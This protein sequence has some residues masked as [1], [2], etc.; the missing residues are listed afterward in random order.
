MPSIIPCLTWVPKGAARE[1]PVRYELSRD[2]YAKVKELES[3]AT[4][5]E[6]V[7]LKTGKAGGDDDLPAEFRMDEYDDD[8]Y[9]DDMDEDVDMDEDG[10]GEDGDE[11]EAEELDAP[12]EI[13]EDPTNKRDGD[14]YEMLETGGIALAMDADSEDEDAE[15]DEIRPTDSLVVVAVTEDEENSH[16]EV[17][18]MSEEGDLYVHHDL[19]LPDFPLCL[20]WLDCPP[21]LGDDGTQSAV[22]NYIA[23]G[24]FQPCIE[25]WNL[26]VMDPLE[27]SATLGGESITEKPVQGVQ[28]GSSSKKKKKK[29]AAKK[30]DD[31]DDE[32]EDEIEFLPG[33]HE[34]AVMCLSWNKQYRNILAS[35]SADHTVKV[36]DV[37]TQQVQH[38]FTHHTDKVQ[39]VQWH[40]TEGWL[41]ATGSYDRTVCL[42]DC[43]TAS[44]VASYKAPSDIEALAWDKH[45]PYFLYCT[46]ED[47]QVVGIDTRNKEKVSFTFV[48]HDKTCTSIS[49]SDKIPGF[50]CTA[51]VD[52]T[53]KVWDSQPLHK[54]EINEPLVVAYKS[55][56][57][58][59]LFTMQCYGSSPFTLAAGGDKGMLAVWNS[60]E[61]A[62]IATHFHGRV[63]DSVQTVFDYSALTQQAAGGA[64]KAAATAA[65]AAAVEDE[66][67]SWMDGDANS[68][69]PS[70]RAA[71]KPGKKA[72]AKGKGKGKGKK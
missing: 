63:V 33:S 4:A 68:D 29:K 49:F 19:Q 55:M 48:A 66:D 22:G 14:T 59:R 3:K 15:D 7:S 58:G 62:A 45:C 25:I 27:P 70:K 17:Q 41:L 16:L 69:E 35:G 39:S 1:R 6:K 44:V 42:L 20:E 37:T 56:S 31:E 34:D 50:M 52:G 40:P 47:G 30:G 54:G 46:C 13:N 28:S 61:T 5:R 43:R 36:W 21:F 71:A 24:T 2:E 26:D 12:R 38:T 51:S 10:D 11:E 67:D 32:D 57:V 9:N 72:T 60:D 65:A 18:L 53:V 64:T 23:V 8:D